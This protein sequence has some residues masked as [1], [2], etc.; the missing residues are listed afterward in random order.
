MNTPTQRPAQ[1]EASRQLALDRY[2]IVDSL[3][4]A[5]YEDIV[6]VAATVCGTP[7][8]L[9]SLLDRDRQWFKAR[10]GLDATHTTRNV[11]VCDV[12]IRHPD[13]L[14]E[15][16]DLTLDPRFADFPAV[17]GDTA[18][19]FYAGMPLVTPEGA[20]I[21]TVC[22]VDHEPRQ[23]SPEQRDALQALA[24]TTMRL[25]QARAREH[26]HGVSQLLEQAQPSAASAAAPT[27]AVGYSVVI[28]ELQ[29]LAG[30]VEQRGERVI[31]KE[32]HALE[33][34]LQALLDRDQGDSVDRVTGSAEFVAVLHGQD[35]QHRQQALARALADFNQRSGLQVLLAAASAESG[36]EA[37]T[38][39]FLRA[40]AALSAAK[41]ALAVAHP[42]I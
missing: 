42:A 18:A 26:D 41:N 38:Q 17:T 24:R 9:V 22:V 37:A 5:A 35:S 32:L 3:P 8:A 25:M 20:P 40:D 15:V 33:L 7:I 31:E 21:G 39:V 34:V 2:R 29:G 1:D 14:L 12:A 30:A 36:H 13:Q 6:Q 19:R 28:M 16:P 11:A 4:E 23:L 10:L 27:S